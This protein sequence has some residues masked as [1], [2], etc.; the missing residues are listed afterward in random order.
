MVFV[1]LWTYPRRLHGE[2]RRDSSMVHAFYYIIIIADDYVL[3]CINELHKFVCP[4][5]CHLLSS[6]PN[7]VCG[8]FSTML[9]FLS[10]LFFF[11]FLLSF[12]FFF[13]SLTLPSA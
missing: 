4:H 13:M 5:L 9:N 8:S 1:I 6:V 10:F 7:E 3:K 12:F 2:N 11:S